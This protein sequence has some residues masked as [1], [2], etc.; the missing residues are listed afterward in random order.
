MRRVCSRALTSATPRSIDVSVYNNSQAGITARY[1]ARWLL[2]ESGEFVFRVRDMSRRGFNTLIA[3]DALAIGADSSARSLFD[4]LSLARAQALIDYAVL[5]YDDYP[6]A[7]GSTATSMAYSY[8]ARDAN[9]FLRG[10]STIAR[11][12]DILIVQRGQAILVSFRADNQVFAQELSTL[13]RFI[14]NLE[15]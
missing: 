11:G 15:F 8:V 2:E 6:L 14:A 3:V 9:P 1:P 10:V 7:D 13:E 12:L 5:G 4:Q